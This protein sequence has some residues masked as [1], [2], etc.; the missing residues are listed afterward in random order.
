VVTN[1]C[2][3]HHR[4][5][6]CGCIGRPAFPTPSFWARDFINDSGASRREIAKLR[7]AI[8]PPM[9]SREIKCSYQVPLLE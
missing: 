7:A 2:A 9:L 6:G 5:R 1:S 3:F 4:T 8:D